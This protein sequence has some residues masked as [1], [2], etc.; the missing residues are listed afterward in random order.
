M[1]GELN[2]LRNHTLIDYNERHFTRIDGSVEEMH[3]DPPNQPTKGIIIVDHG[4]RRNES[5][6]R[7]LDLVE[8]FRQRNPGAI[9]EP[10]HMELDEPSIRQSFAKCVERGANLIIV[11]PFF[12]LPGRHWKHDIPDL[13]AEAAADHPGVRYLVTA[14]LDLHPLIM[15]IMSQR[16]DDCLAVA[17]GKQLE[18][19]VCNNVDQCQVRKA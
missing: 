3:D 13:A 16:I 19:P 17:T 8:M 4:S 7:L 18:C 10:A 12:L 9:I 14:P 6:R 15:D 2:C 11:N 1:A 5:N